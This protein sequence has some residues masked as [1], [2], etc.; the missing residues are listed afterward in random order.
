[1]L[2]A[3]N[4][5]DLVW[6]SPKYQL[7]ILDFGQKIRVVNLKTLAE[8]SYPFEDIDKL[9]IV[10]G[11]SQHIFKMD[12]TGEKIVL[13]YTSQDSVKIYQFNLKTKEINLDE[14]LVNFRIKHGAPFMICSDLR[15]LLWPR[16]DGTYAYQATHSYIELQDE[17]EHHH[18]HEGE[19]K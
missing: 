10:F 3:S 17:L 18:E 9:S 7:Y 15:A 6:D 2:K 14:E 11:L 16:I 8:T 12:P 5:A 4:I 13:G 1:L 19:D